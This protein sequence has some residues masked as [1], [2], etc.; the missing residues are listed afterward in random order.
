MS[1]LR[2]AGRWRLSSPGRWPRT[3]SA[4]PV[5]R[6]EEVAAFVLVGH[7][8]QVLH[9]QMHEPRLIGLEGF[10]PRLFRFGLQGLERTDAVAAQ[11]TVQPERDTLG[12][13]NSRTT[14]SRSSRGSI[15]VLRSSTT[16]AS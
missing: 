11:T 7:L 8:R 6:H 4:S 15:K 12:V 14:A 13:M 5:D 9:V 2:S 16:T 10:V 3:P 1:E